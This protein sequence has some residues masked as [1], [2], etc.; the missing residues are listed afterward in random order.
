MV[1]IQKL[2]RATSW[3][4]DLWRLRKR[5][6]VLYFCVLASILEICGLCKTV[7][8]SYAPYTPKAV[9]CWVASPSLRLRDTDLSRQAATAY[10][11]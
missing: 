9:L 8:R 2:V 5:N 11:L 4:N 1:K 3:L 10:L 6:V 7:S